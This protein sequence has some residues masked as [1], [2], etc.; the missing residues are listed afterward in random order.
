MRYTE[1]ESRN[2]FSPSVRCV[3]PMS[4]EYRLKARDD[5]SRLLSRVDSD[6][7]QVLLDSFVDHLFSQHIFDADFTL[8][9]AEAGH[10]SLLAPEGTRMQDFVAWCQRLPER[11]VGFFKWLR[12][13]WPSVTLGSVLADFPPSGYF[14]SRSSSL[15][16]C[17]RFLR[18]PSRFWPSRKARLLSPNCGG[19]DHSRRSRR[20]SRPT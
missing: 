4:H 5:V 10:D 18:M 17:F 11:E 15:Q 7:D 9:G 1:G 13:A 20:L 14:N 19:F 6:N 16:A 12:S 8:V 2:G 3:V